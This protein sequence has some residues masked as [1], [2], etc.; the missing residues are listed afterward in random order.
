MYY[1]IRDEEY[2][3]QIMLG[4]PKCCKEKKDNR[5]G[6][7]P[8]LKV[9]SI[10]PENSK[11]RIRGYCSNCKKEYVIDVTVYNHKRKEY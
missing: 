10:T 4:C 2:G 6:F 3:V 11:A 1:W 5:K 7:G 8:V 9:K